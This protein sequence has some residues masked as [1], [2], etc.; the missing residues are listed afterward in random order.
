METNC[1]RSGKPV[2]RGVQKLSWVEAPHLVFM[3]E[4]C[5]LLRKASQA[6]PD[7]NIITPH[8]EKPKPEGEGTQAAR[9]LKPSLPVRAPFLFC[10]RVCWASGERLAAGAKD[11]TCVFSSEQPLRLLGTTDSMWQKGNSRY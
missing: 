11:I 1:S 4:I 3:L 2:L 7:L 10:K 5:D 6:P 8:T 9:L